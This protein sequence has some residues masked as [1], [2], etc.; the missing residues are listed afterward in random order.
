MTFDVRGG[1]LPQIEQSSLFRRSLRSLCEGFD[2]LL[3]ELRLTDVLINET[4]IA[5]CDRTKGNSSWPGTPSFRERDVFN[6][7]RLQLRALPDSQYNKVVSVGISHK[8]FRESLS[9]IL[10]IYENQDSCLASLDNSHLPSLKTLLQLS[11]RVA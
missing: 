3:S 6:A 8:P 7:A 10:S 4:P 2:L 11:N 9:R 5:G 1:W